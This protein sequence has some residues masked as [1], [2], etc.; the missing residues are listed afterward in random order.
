MEVVVRKTTASDFLSHGSSNCAVAVAF[1]EHSVVEC[2]E[3]CMASIKVK[4]IFKRIRNGSDIGI[5][6]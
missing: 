6:N 3:K 2:K 1:I 4:H 5:F